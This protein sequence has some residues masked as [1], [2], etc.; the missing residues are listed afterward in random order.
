LSS[1][2]ADELEA[3]LVVV[4]QRLALRWQAGGPGARKAKGGHTKELRKRSTAEKGRRVNERDPVERIGRLF[5]ALQ[6][7]WT[8]KEALCL[9]KTIFHVDG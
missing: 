1:A 3:R 5:R 2:V 9:G 8:K 6:K 4:N 7:P